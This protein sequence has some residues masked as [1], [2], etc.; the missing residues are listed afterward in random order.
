M[1]EGERVEEGGR[2]SVLPAVLKGCVYM[3]MLLPVWVGHCGVYC[4]RKSM[5]TKT[6]S[7]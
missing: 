1:E 4:P 2:V 7:W 6:V 5:P 3:C